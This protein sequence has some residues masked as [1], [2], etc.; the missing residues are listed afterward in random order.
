[1]RLKLG[2]SLSRIRGF[3]G[4][5]AASCCVRVFP[6]NHGV[7]HGR[8]VS[9]FRP[10]LEIEMAY[11]DAFALRTSP[12]NT[13]LFSEVGLELNGS[14]LTVLSLLARLGE[15]PWSQALNWARL[16]RPAIIDDLA[17][18]I[19]QMPLCPEALLDARITASRLILLL[20][21]QAGSVARGNRDL[22]GALTIPKQLRLMIFY[23]ALA[24]GMAMSIISITAPPA[25]VAAPAEQA[26]VPQTP[27]TVVHTP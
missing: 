21:V 20:P 1:V 13:F 4:F 12:F 6:V 9:G 27:A 23:F 5:V 26:N 2:S 19:R 16:P 15:D 24:F 18:C 10:K 3:D 25:S 7:N 22:T 14:A 17:D 11:P 8:R